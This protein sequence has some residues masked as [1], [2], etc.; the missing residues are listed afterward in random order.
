MEATFPTDQPDLHDGQLGCPRKHD[1]GPPD[2]R[3]AWSGGQPEGRDH[4]AADQGELPR[5]PVGAGV[6]HLHPR[7]PQGSGRHRA[8]YRRL[9]LPDPSS[10]RRLAGRHHPR[11][12]LRH[13]ARPDDADRVQSCEDGASPRTRTS[14]P[15]AYARTSA[16]DVVARR[17]RGAG[18]AGERPRRRHDRRAGRGRRRGGQGPLA[19]S[20]ATSKVGTCAKCYGRSLATGKLV[21]IGEAVG[22][23][24]AQSIGEP[25]TQLTMRTFHTGG[26]AGD[27]I[28][29]GLPARGRAVRGPQAQGRRADLRGRRPGRDRGDRQDAQDRR[30][31]R[32]RLR[33]A[34]RTPSPSGPGCCVADGDHVEVGQQLIVGA[35]DPQEVLR[36][37][38]A[39]PGAAA[40]GRRGP[41]GLPQAGRVDPRQAH[42]DHRAAD[43]A[44]GH[45]H[46]VG[47]RRA[48][49]RRAGRAR[50]ASRR[51]TVGWSPRAARPPRAVPS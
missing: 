51:R 47:R 46:R 6:L 48:A 42:R 38:G 1:A 41:G 36:I 14:R 29:Q 40:P 50:R 30:R 45:D 7:R 5:G 27:D 44:P 23:I 31:P 49:A 16:E 18:T 12:R 39:A 22:I 34:R 32:R 33:G 28:T 43:A 35:I 15:A 26:V 10:G 17:R 24:A 19:C 3:H 13:R 4:P 21:D 20:P 9:R 25:G 37:L 2:R 11:G 8:A